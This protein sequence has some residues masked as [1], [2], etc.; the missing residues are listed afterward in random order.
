MVRDV[1]TM[2]FLPPEELRPGES[3]APL[4]ASF[5][6][7][8]R[9]ARPNMASKVMSS[10]HQFIAS[11]IVSPTKLSH[12]SLPTAFTPPNKDES[13]SNLIQYLISSRRSEQE[14]K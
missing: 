1:G 2:W 8:R 5:S 12:V 13:L 7:P 9:C 6:F 4:S 3:S 11:V 10:A 14:K